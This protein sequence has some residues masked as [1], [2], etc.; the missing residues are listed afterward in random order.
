M[1]M[2]SP[3]PSTSVHSMMC[4]LPAPA[5]SRPSTSSPPPLRPDPALA[6]DPPRPAHQLCARIAARRRASPRGRMQRLSD[7][8]L[9]HHPERQV[10]VKDPSPGQMVDEEAPEQGPDQSREAPY[11][12]EQTLVAAAIARRNQVA[13]RGDDRNH[14]AT[15]ADSLHEAEA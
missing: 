9:R 13:D 12:A 5:G 3:I 2:P 8:P 15:A 14:Q 7:D 11:R 6:N 1:T 4:P 10:D